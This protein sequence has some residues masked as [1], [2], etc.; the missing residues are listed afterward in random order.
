MVIM[1]LKKTPVYEALN[2][3][4]YYYLKQR[5]IEKTLSMVTDDIYSLGTGN[6]EI[7][8]NKNQ[9][10]KLI[11][12]EIDI[13][14]ISIDYKILNYLEKEKI[15]DFWECICNVEV[16]VYLE[17]DKKVTYFTRLTAS[18]EKIDGKILASTLHMSEASIHQE[19]NEF[20][21]LKYSSETISKLDRKSEHE[22]LEIVLEMMP[23]GIIG[24]YLEERYPLY[25]VNDKFLKLAGYEAYDDFFADIKGEIVNT[26]HP[27]DID[28]VNK[29]VKESL[30]VRNQYEVEYRLRKKNNSYIW[31]R[32]IGRKISTLEGREVILS[33]VIDVSEQ[34][35]LN[36]RLQR[37]ASKDALTNL[38]N[39][40]YGI[41]LINKKIVTSSK[42]AFIIMD[43]DNFKALNDIY[44]HSEGD[45]ILRFVSIQLKRNFRKN[46]VVLRLG[47]DEFVIFISDF[48]D[49]N[50]IKIK[51]DEINKK[52]NMEI[53][54]K[55]IESRS[56]ISFGMVISNKNVDFNRL[57][58]KADEV[59]YEIK[60]NNK[61]NFKVLDL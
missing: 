30:S 47:G 48:L 37:E 10:R 4:F 59:L 56:S 19:D 5:D 32:D 42:Y 15:K 25:I 33:V 49:E 20:F 23:G 22:L 52:Y 16:I 29:I 55:Y 61:G 26:I 44:G 24:G 8:L 34:V 6:G 58:E 13:L 21:P 53:N 46:S 14:P 27:D 12:T 41:D 57:Y 45:N 50:I 3:F 2:L 40:K 31:V 35:L 54:K 7:A 11:A 1:D 51:L 60:R 38:Y 17:K 36:K 28:F 43:I 9:F 39:R 18:F